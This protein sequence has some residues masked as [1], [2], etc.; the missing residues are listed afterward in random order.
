M[1]ALSEVHL[2][3]M[4]LGRIGIS[5]ALSG[6][7]DGTLANC[8]DTSLEKTVAERLYEDCRLRFLTE[9]PWQFAR[10]YALLAE[11][12]D[13]TGE[14]WDDEW[15]L[16]YTYPTDGLMMRRFL[17]DVGQGYN[18]YGATEYVWP[19]R[20]R[21]YAFVIRDDGT[22]NKVI[23]TDVANADANMEYTQDFTDL[24][25]FPRPAFAG[26]SWLLAHEIAM[27]LGATNDKARAAYEMY[28]GIG[29]QAMAFSNN[30]EMPRPDADESFLSH[31]GGF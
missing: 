20:S 29:H 5:R 11:A 6:D 14:I 27:P 24:T 10:V 21:E 7:V 18:Y 1:V 13:G 30:E 4:A 28:V 9:F 31:R 26:L 25:R 12:S 17:N 2:T 8:T 3:N 15:D 23:L 19:Y 16:S 22:G